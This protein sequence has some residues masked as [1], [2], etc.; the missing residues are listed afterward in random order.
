MERSEVFKYDD[1]KKAVKDKEAY[2]RIL[3]AKHP[4]VD[5]E[6]LEKLASDSNPEVRAAAC[7]HKLATP[8][9]KATAALLKN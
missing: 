9:M 6:L 2:V 8:E 5:L 4:L 7:E 3:A 1:L